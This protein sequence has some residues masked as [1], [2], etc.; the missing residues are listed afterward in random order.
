MAGSGSVAWM[1]ESRGEIVVKANGTD[2]DEIFMM[3]ADSDAA[4]AEIDDSVV[5]VWT[6]P[7]MLDE[8]RKK[9]VNEGLE[10]DQAELGRVA[11]SPIDVEKRGALQ[12]LKL[13]SNLEELEDVRKVDT[14]LNITEDLV[15]T[16]AAA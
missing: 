7:H 8:V 2:P 12:V 11:S 10:I 15:A 1:F 3:A 16:Y 13:V 6:K 4:D 14:N 5:Y 9:L